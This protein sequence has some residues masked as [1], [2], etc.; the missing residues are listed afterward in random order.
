MIEVNLFSI[1][2]ADYE[3]SVGKCVSRARFDKEAMSTSILEFVKGF[4]RD[5]LDNLE[6]AISNSDL[7]SLI[8]SDTAINTVDLASIKYLLGQLG[9]KLTIWNVAD[10]E[11]NANTVASGTLE[12][13]VINSNFMQSDYPTVTKLIPADN[14][15]LAEIIGTIVEQS[16][17]FDEAKFS[18]VKN[19]F[20]ILVNNLKDENGKLGKVNYSIITKI[21]SLLDQMGFTV[22]C[23]TPEED[24]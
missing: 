19:P 13:N 5:N 17:L 10:D 6:S 9:Y 23:A 11:E 24:A 16:G 7:V 1:P 22:F 8:N 18:G 20:T 12:Y 3:A 2:T 15:N 21:Y 4:L 14:Q